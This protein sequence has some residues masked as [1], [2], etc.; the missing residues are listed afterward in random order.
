MVLTQPQPF[1]NHN[2]GSITFGPDEMLYIGLGDGGSAGDPQGN[3]QALDTWLGKLLRIDPSTDGD[4][5]YA[6]PA[7]NPLGPD[8]GRPEIYAWG[9]RNPWRFSF[10]RATGDLWI[11]DVGQNE[12]EEINHSTAAEGSGNGA[13]YGWRAFEGDAV[14]DPDTE[15]P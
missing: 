2:G 6:I 4:A 8:G 13:N 14:Y 5:P 1:P 11:G 7:D 12:V 9:L 10:D 3:G 15:A